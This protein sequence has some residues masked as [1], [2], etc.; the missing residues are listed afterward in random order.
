MSRRFGDWRLATASQLEMRRAI[1]PKIASVS[2]VPSASPMSK[3]CSICPKELVT[4]ARHS[5][6]I[7]PPDLDF[8]I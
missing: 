5:T 7:A 3:S 4:Y 1:A 2:A 6:R 8:I